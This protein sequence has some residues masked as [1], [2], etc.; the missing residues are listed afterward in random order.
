MRIRNRVMRLKRKIIII[1]RSSLMVSI[2]SPF[3]RLKTDSFKKSKSISA[4][5][6]PTTLDN[7]V[8]H[9]KSNRKICAGRSP[10]GSPMTSSRRSIIRR[11]C[12]IKRKSCNNRGLKVGLL[13]KRRKRRRW[14]GN[15]ST[16]IVIKRMTSR[17]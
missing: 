15:T 17:I 9:L 8:T 1:L 16:S 5:I 6:T 10:P 11:N 13:S 12:T 7:S 14:G 4:M 2:V 3:P